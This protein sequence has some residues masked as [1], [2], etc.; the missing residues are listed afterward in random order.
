VSLAGLGGASLA[1]DIRAAA[2]PPG[3][4]WSTAAGT[5][6]FLLPAL[7]QL[8]ASSARAA[9]VPAAALP[10]AVGAAAFLLA[11]RRLRSFA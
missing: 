10:A 8:Y 11:A 1:A 9:H 5:V 2:V 6:L 7:I 3:A 4:L